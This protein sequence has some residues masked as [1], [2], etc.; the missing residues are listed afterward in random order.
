V[1]FICNAFEIHTYIVC[2]KL[3]Y[4]LGLTIRRWSDS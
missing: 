1:R 2:D 3:A 4:Y